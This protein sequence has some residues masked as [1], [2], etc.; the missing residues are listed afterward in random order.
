MVARIFLER[1]G[2]DLSALKFPHRIE[3]QMSPGTSTMLDALRLIAA[4]LVFLNHFWGL[5]FYRGMVIHSEMAHDA[6]GAC[7][8]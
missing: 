3:N 7:L 8:W 6:V 4:L 2:F 5:W 1:G